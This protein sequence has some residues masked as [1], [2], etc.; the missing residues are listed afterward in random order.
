MMPQ[1]NG[2]SAK[3]QSGKSSDKLVPSFR[4][5]PARP[6]PNRMEI[7]A[8]TSSTKLRRGRRKLQIMAMR[9]PMP[10]VKYKSPT[11]NIGPGSHC[12][13]IITR[14]QP[15]DP[16]LSHADGQP[17]QRYTN[18]NR[19]SWLS[20]NWRDSRHWLQRVVR[21]RATASFVTRIRQPEH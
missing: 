9:L 16:K 21:R 12:A 10:T 2:T 6:A 7:T 17:T 8:Q 3:S 13:N 19:I 5:R 15:N 18:G 14:K 1:S 20:Q 4:N 11:N